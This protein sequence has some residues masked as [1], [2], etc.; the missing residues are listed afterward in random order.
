MH[1]KAPFSPEQIQALKL[2]QECGMFHPYTCS[3]CECNL[4][5]SVDGMVCSNYKCCHTQDWVLNWT[6]DLKNVEQLIENLKN[7]SLVKN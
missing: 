2:Y 3:H 5:P 7:Y 6:C 4:F 1:V